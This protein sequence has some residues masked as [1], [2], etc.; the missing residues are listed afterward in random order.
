MRPS[1][2]NLVMNGIVQSFTNQKSLDE[3]QSTSFANTWKAFNGEAI[4][5][6]D[7]FIDETAFAILSGLKC[8]FGAFNC[9]FK[10]GHRGNGLVWIKDGS[11]WAVEMLDEGSLPLHKISVDGKEEIIESDEKASGVLSALICVE[12]GGGGGTSENAV[13]INTAQTITG[14]KTFK[15]PIKVNEIDNENGNAMLRYKETEGKNVVG[16]SNY[17]LTLMGSGDRPSYSKDGSD[18]EGNPLALK[19]DVD[20]NWDL[21]M[22][23][24]GVGRWRNA[25]FR[26]W[27]WESNNIIYDNLAKYY[28]DCSYL[29]SGLSWVNQNGNDRNGKDIHFNNPTN[30]FPK[31]Y[32]EYVNAFAS[33]QSTGS[34]YMPTLCGNL[35]FGFT[36]SLFSKVLIEE[37]CTCEINVAG[38]ALFND[39]PNLTEIGA[40]D[41]SLTENE[42]SF[43]IQNSPNVKSI[44]CKHFKSSFN[45]SYSTAFEESDLI[46]IISNLDTVTT[47]QILT[48]GATNIAKLT[49]DEKKVATDKGWTLA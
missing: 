44:H 9:H 20:S 47:T 19:S 37:G 7:L 49:D 1:S 28:S 31:E 3:A 30:F 38:D 2:K 43:F 29:F 15:Q 35:A 4:T 27:S 45:I 25:T 5:L 46:E 16:G 22:A 40:F 33:M 32:T 12:N 41:M 13:T 14:S 24:L 36:S 34:I 11:L 18:F 42:Q 10:D 8:S 17:P 6:G 39:M 21:L 48:M 23:N 26:A